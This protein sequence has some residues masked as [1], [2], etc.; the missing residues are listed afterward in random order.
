MPRHAFLA[1]VALASALPAAARAQAPS[2]PPVGISLSASLAG[3]GEFGLAQGKAGLLEAEIAAGWSSE[4]QGLGA[5][6]AAVIGNE[7]D[8]SVALRPGIRWRVSGT[9]LRVRLA[10]DASDARDRGF[11]WR[12]LLAGAVLETR[13]TSL[14][15]L[16][17]ELDTGVPLRSGAGVPLLLRGGAAFRF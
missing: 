1:A 14:L 17:A 2:S 10:L 7:P 9:P 4:R 16:Y 3:G 15:G 6:L 13:L 8:R 12:W 5:E 11:G